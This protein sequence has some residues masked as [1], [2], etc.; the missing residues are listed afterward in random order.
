MRLPQGA[1]NYERFVA[2]HRL[3]LSPVLEGLGDE[4]RRW[5]DAHIST[6]SESIG[7]GA[8]VPPLFGMF[9]VMTPAAPLGYHE[10]R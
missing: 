1:S 6:L 2:E 5:D 10:A 8:T 9:N 4:P 7:T 3:A